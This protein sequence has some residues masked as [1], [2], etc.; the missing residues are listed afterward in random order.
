MEQF[1]RYMEHLIRAEMARS[2]I[3]RYIAAVRSSLLLA[4]KKGLISWTPPPRPPFPPA[5][6]DTAIGDLPNLDRALEA[7]SKETSLI[8]VRDYAMVLLIGR[9]ALRRAEVATLVLNEVS[10]E[11]QEISIRRSDGRAPDVLRVTP[12]VSSALERWIVM[13]GAWP[14]PMFVDVRTGHVKHRAISSRAIGRILARYDLESPRILRHM[15]ITSHLER[16][17]GDLAGARELGRIRRA[18]TM[19][20]Y[21]RNRQ[22]SRSP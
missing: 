7:L 19:G 22:Q 4:E 12:E 14:G 1:A 5:Y 21:E 6:Q 16:N 10:L 20:A 8:A 17:R 2:T 3:A 15:A 13:R 9:L 18:S 11:R